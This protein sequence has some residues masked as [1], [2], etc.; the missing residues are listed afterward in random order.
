MN[1]AYLII[2]KRDSHALPEA[3]TLAE[4]AGY[5]IARVWKSRYPNRVGRGLIAEIASHA[6][7][8]RPSVIIF[9]GNPQPSA[10]YKLMLE[11]RTRVIDRVQ[12]ILEI[13]V[14]HAGSREAMLQ[15]EMARIKHELPLVRELI[16]RSKMGELPGFLGP[17]RYAIDSYYRHLTSRLAKLRREL[18]KLR[19][20]RSARIETRRHAGML[21]V[22][23]TGY[24]S[25]GKT[26]LFNKLTGLSK[27]TGPEYFTTLHPKH[28]RV[29]VSGRDVVFIDTVGFIRDV[30]PSIIEAFYSTL[31]EVASSDSIIFVVDISED[32]QSI[33]E[34][35]LAGFETLSRIGAIGKPIIIA[36]N[37][38][39]LLSEDEL[40]ERLSL[41]K[42]EALALGAVRVIP[43][44]AAK[45]V[46]VKRV[47]ED[48]VSAALEPANLG[49]LWEGLRAEAW[50]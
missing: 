12:L 48:A 23:I 2:P 45:E 37:K 43:V 17:G 34:K 39:D 16:R 31:E 50:P 4:T 6:E 15:I 18:E 7:Q 29:R 36:A 33:R 46:N 24:A 5:Q 32:F 26:T 25:A 9:Y 22:A 42:A 49:D 1:K 38:I 3:V 21:H 47:A 40:D 30:P 35:L 27:P 11:T 13:F 19:K 44:S 28:Y 20:L 14:K 8:D 41:I 10:V